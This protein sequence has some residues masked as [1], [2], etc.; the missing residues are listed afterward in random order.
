MTTPDKG[1]SGCVLI[2]LSAFPPAGLGAYAWWG[3][4]KWWQLPVSERHFDG[5]FWAVSAIAVVGPL[6]GLALLMLAR[7]IYRNTD[8]RGYDPSDPKGPRIKW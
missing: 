5:R 4:A 7:R 3:L 8:F 2:G 1:T 6:L